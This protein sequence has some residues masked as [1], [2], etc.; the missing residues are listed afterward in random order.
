[1]ITKYMV[2]VP[3]SMSRKEP[4]TVNPAQALLNNSAE[5]RGMSE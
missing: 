5:Y 3:L 1:M 2:L 4:P